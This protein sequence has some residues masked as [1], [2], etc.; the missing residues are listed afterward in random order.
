MTE[1]HN[2]RLETHALSIGSGMKS[3]RASNQQNDIAQENSQAKLQFP[4]SN[5]LP[6]WTIPDRS[7]SECLENR[8]IRAFQRT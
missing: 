2:I 6:F 7:G 5:M 1:N 3:N 4:N 8:Q